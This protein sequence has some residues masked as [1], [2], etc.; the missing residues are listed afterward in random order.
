MRV[1]APCSAALKRFQAKWKPVRAK[2]TRKK[3]NPTG[4]VEPKKAL[5]YRDQTQKLEI[6]GVDEAEVKGAPSMEK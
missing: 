3:Q 5:A 6:C 2:K 1:L 4:F